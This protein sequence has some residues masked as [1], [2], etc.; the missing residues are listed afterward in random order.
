M[1]S[2]P[3]EE[4]N[5]KNNQGD[6]NDNDQD[7]DN[8]NDNDHD[9]LNDLDLPASSS[10]FLHQSNQSAPKVNHHG[11]PSPQQPST[12]SITSSPSSAASASASSSSSSPRHSH[13]S[14]Q[15]GQ[16]DQS[17]TSSRH[18]NQSG[19]S[20][21]SNK[22]E[23]E[24]FMDPAITM[25]L[26]GIIDSVIVSNVK[27]DILFVNGAT[28]NMFGYSKEYLLGQD[29]KLLMPEPYRSQHST[30]LSAYQGGGKPKLLGVTRT[31]RGQRS[32]GFIF[33]LD[34]SLGLF[35]F[36]A[37]NGQ[38]LFVATMRE[39]QHSSEETW[40]QSNSSGSSEGK[41]RFGELVK[42][43]TFHGLESYIKLF[44]EEEVCFTLFPFPFPFPFLSFFSF[45]F[46]LI[47]IEF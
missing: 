47:L 2:N 4:D 45:L 25:T 5:L 26:E 39:V 28:E 6:D 35:P 14:N 3:E 29:V 44:E 21:F 18:S 27:G 34:L 38:K 32:N 17:I 23:K 7:N 31:L 22:S 24:V 1:E 33:P 36:M 10:S 42:L 40:S 8:D 19:D 12:N 43:L 16:S 46:D 30:Y 9:N 13:H 15:S 41:A 37:G 11:N 20:T